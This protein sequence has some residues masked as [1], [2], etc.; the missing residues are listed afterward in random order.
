MTFVSPT[1]CCLIVQGRFTVR[2]AEGAPRSLPAPPEVST[3]SKYCGL[4][5]I[6]EFVKDNMFT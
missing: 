4:P 1:M 3:S 5:I 2:N 6:P